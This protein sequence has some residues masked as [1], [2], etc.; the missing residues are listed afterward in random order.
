MQQRSE[1]EEPDDDTEGAV[2]SADLVR[3]FYAPRFLAGPLRVACRLR[4]RS[5]TKSTG[6]GSDFALGSGGFISAQTGHAVQSA[7]STL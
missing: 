3:I 4:C 6:N 7:S 5:S 1:E 2:S